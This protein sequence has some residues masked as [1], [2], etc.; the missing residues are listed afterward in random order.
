MPRYSEGP[1]GTLPVI[2]R[3]RLFNGGVG[4]E[5]KYMQYVTDSIV[6]WQCV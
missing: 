2:V 3:Q 6:T 1:G 5:L 4:G